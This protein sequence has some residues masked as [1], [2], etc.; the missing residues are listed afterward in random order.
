MSLQSLKRQISETEAQL[1]ALKEQLARIESNKDTDDVK[2]AQPREPVKDEA[3]TNGKSK[4]PLTPEEYGRYGRQMIVPSIGIQG[5]SY[6][7]I[8]TG[9]LLT[10]S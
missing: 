1:T 6:G 5:R 10:I 7:F 4:W 9:Y 2:E 8:W 3:S